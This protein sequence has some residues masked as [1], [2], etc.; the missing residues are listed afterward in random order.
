MKRKVLTACPR[1]CYS[2]CSFY[3]ETE[4]NR[5]TAIYPDPANR[6]VPEGPCIKGLSYI[7]RAGSSSRITTPLL[8][9]KN[10][11]Y[12]EISKEKALDIIAEKLSCYRENHSP[13]SVLYYTGSGMSGLTN[14]IGYNFFSLYGGATTT[15]GNYC[16]PAGLEAVRATLG[17]VKHNVPWDIE[18][19]GIIVLWGKNP[20][21]TNIQETAFISAASSRGAKIISVDP[22]RTPTADKADIHL[23]VNPGTDA[24][25]ALAVCRIIIEKNRHNSEFIDRNVSGFDD[26]RKSLTID[27]ADAA[28]ITGLSE[29]QIESFA[30]MLSDGTPLTVIPG[31]GVQRYT[32]G[33]QTIRAIL[34]VSI[35][36]GNIGKPGSSFNYANLQGYIFDR[37]REPLSYY[38]EIDANPVFRRSVSIARLGEEMIAQR[39]PT[40]RMAFIERGNPMTQACD[41]NLVEKAFRKLEFIVAVDQFMNDTTSIADLILPAKN[42]FEQQDIISSYWSPYIFY[43]PAILKPPEGVM[44]ET[45]IF[46][47]LAKRLKIKFKDSD[48]PEPGAESTDRWLEE[49]IK[50]YSELTLQTLKAGPV[51]APGLQEIAFSD[52][53]FSTPEGKI[54]LR[55]DELAERWGVDP[56]PSYSDPFG[57]ITGTG[58]FIF[59][60][61]NNRNRI[62]SQFGNLKIIKEN[63]P[64]PFIE[65]SAADAARKNISDGDMIRIFNERGEVSVKANVNFRIKEGCLSMPNGWWRMEGGGGNQL[66][67]GSETDMGYGTAFLNCRVYMEKINTK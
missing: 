35:I 4:D 1:N 7:E 53:K 3:A 29:D 31:Y 17:E 51:I 52:N 37:Y 63:D 24:A 8:K 22:R 66:T 58:D 50:G 60:T 10:G 21:E 41:T 16:W 59:L 13:Q 34:A 39:D 5:L 6:A 32:N 47:H 43:R 14:S 45:E 56:L 55:S 11:D 33:G 23:S 25:L 57:N 30:L 67:E 20:A 2:T 9:D 62:H 18:N 44:P 48:I 61:P 46:Y 49:R 15:Y 65:V 28:R 36:T 19:A 40:L 64:E 42:M 27:T 38:P 26:F 54:N 12:Q